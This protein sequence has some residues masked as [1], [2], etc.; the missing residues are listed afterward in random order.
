MMSVFS[1]YCV[2]SR[3]PVRCNISFS[4]KIAAAQYLPLKN[5]MRI[6]V[7]LDRKCS[8]SDTSSFKAQLNDEACPC[9]QSHCFKK[10][11]ETPAKH[12][13]GDCLSKVSLCKCRLRLP[14]VAL[15]TPAT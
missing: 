3:V 4:T 1:S 5:E 11:E 8:L 2:I 14:T 12:Y 9:S 6:L 13:A 7:E 10:N 15:H